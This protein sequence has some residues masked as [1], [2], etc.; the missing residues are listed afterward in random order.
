MGLP[1]FVYGMMVRSLVLVTG[2]RLAVI[3][4]LVLATTASV[5]MLNDFWVAP[6]ATVVE[7]GTVA[8]ADELVSNTFAPPAG[9]A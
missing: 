2:P 7:A 8:F 5:D 4:T 6:G 1:F 3:V 9:A